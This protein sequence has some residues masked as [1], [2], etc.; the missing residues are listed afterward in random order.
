MALGIMRF[1]QNFNSHM[2]AQ[3]LEGWILQGQAYGMVDNSLSIDKKTVSKWSAGF[4]PHIKVPVDGALIADSKSV[5]NVVS[6]D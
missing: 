2:V 6:S 5:F 3:I 1:G 4:I